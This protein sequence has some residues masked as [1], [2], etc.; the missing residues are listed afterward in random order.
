MIYNALRMR[1]PQEMGTVIQITNNYKTET[2]IAGILI[3]VVGCG[4]AVIWFTKSWR[5]VVEPLLFHIMVMRRPRE[6][7]VS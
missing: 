4:N 2:P 1:L 3:Y 7:S 5:C 6:R